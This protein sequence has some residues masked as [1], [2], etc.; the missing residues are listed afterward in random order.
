[1]PW[2]VGRRCDYCRMRFGLAIGLREERI[3]AN[4]A[5]VCVFCFLSFVVDV[6]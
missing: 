2:L 4:K 5:I 1:M 3:V 6:V